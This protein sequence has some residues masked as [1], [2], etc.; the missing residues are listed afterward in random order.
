MK[1]A[2]IDFAQFESTAQQKPIP[3]DVPGWEGVFVRAVTLGE[4]ERGI[5]DSE[6]DPD[7][8]LRRAF[9]RVVCHEDGTLWFDVSDAKHMELIARQPMWL[10]MRVLTA[11]DEAL[12][13]PN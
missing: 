13:P 11:A 8:N 9:A 10:I 6:N 5:K 3:V 12:K 1:P 4:Y 2:A 7:G